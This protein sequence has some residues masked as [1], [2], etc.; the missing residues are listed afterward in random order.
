MLFLALL[1][2]MVNIPLRAAESPVV[3]VSVEPAEVIAGTPVTLRVSVYAPTW[4]PRPP[5]FPNFELPN[6][7]TRLPPN[8]SGPVSRRVG[9]STWSG[10]ER[11]YQ[12]TPLIGGEFRIRGR[13]I[14]VTY[15]DPSS[16]EPITAQLPVP[17][18]VFTATVPAGAESLDP[19][20]AGESLDLRRV[21]ERETDDLAAGDALV[22]RYQATLVGMPSLFLP[23]LVRVSAQPGL[24]VYPEEPVLRDQNGR[25]VR[26]EKLTLVFDSGGEFT[27][28][29]LELRWWNLQTQ[30]IEVAKLAALD[31][32]VSGPVAAQPVSAGNNES[33]TIWW[34]AAAAGLSLLV[35]MA[36][37]QVKRGLAARKR[38]AAAYL[39]S[40]PYAF[41]QLVKALRSGDV[42]ISYNGLLIWL[43]RLDPHLDLQRFCNTVQDDLLVRQ[44]DLLRNRQY[45]DAAGEP[46][47]AA[48]ARQ[49]TAARKVWFGQADPQLSGLL[50]ALN[51]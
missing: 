34:L 14:S 17:D 51:P 23:P 8:S 29:Q 25:A 4:F 30:Q 6:T 37:K 22:L 27:L 11:R 9:T 5:E 39:A 31:I 42:K 28:P 32:P 12:V 38:A 50:P 24:S 26:E 15:A 36:R 33:D 18:M 41:E 43:A 2:S 48:L 19:Y 40:E 20:I 35:L 45:G 16:R 13:Q 49:L 1:E 47:F 44:L 21:M 7:I 3:Q 10:I 46:D